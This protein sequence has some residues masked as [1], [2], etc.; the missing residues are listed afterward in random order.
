MAEAG[1][2]KRESS[3]EINDAAALWALRIDDAALDMDA[4]ADFDAWLEGDI[5]RAGAFA[6]A[7]AALVTVKRAKALG[8]EFEPSSFLREG[9]TQ[10]AVDIVEPAVDEPPPRSGLTRRRILAGASALAASGAF[11]FFLPLRPAS[12]QIYE[13]G[14]GET[15]LIS[16]EDGSTITMNTA[17]R[18]EASLDDA[19]YLVRLIHGEALFEVAAPFVIEAGEIALH[20]RGATFTVC[21]L[22][23]RPLEVKVCEGDI[24]VMRDRF[25]TR[26]LGANMQATLPLN[27]DMIESAVTPEALARDLAWRE[28]MLSFEDTPLQEAA[29]TFARY[30]DWHIQIADPAVGAETVTGRFAA[31]NPEGF[32][33]AAALGLNLR[34][35][36]MRDGVMLAR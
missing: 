7:Q 5:R 32:A 20:A 27:G 30:S 3:S 13:T 15:R 18:I 14:R 26:R 35:Q 10:E 11:A 17:S 12:A 9:G 19:H 28:G 33:R 22:D 6:R 34:V 31:N 24:E 21:R 16:L 36:T 25:Q 8:T 23:S 2:S 29:T 1:M 4:Q